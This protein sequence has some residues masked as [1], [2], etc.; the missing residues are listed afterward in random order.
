MG[1]IFV[2]YALGLNL[3]ITSR[4][5]TKNA[6][7]SILIGAIA[8]IVLDPIFIFDFSLAWAFG[9]HLYFRRGVAG[10]S[11]TYSADLH[12]W[13]V[14]VRCTDICPNILCRH[15]TSEEIPVQCFAEENDHPYSIGDCL[16]QP[17]RRNGHLLCWANR[18]CYI[19]HHIRYSSPS[20]HEEITEG[21]LALWV[22]PEIKNNAK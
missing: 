11:W 7:F 10:F 16:I 4:G 5:G 2:Q 18:G 3:F 13:N 6:M 19:C 1:T 14:T 17:I 15:G 20:D 8:N 12:E 21:R 22:G 9:T